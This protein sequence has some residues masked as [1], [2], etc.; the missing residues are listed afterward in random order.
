MWPKHHSDHT[1]DRKQHPEDDSQQLHT[2]QLLLALLHDLLLP[3]QAWRCAVRP[4]RV[5]LLNPQA[6]SG[7][8]DEAGVP[9]VALQGEHHSLGDRGQAGCHG[10]WQV[11]GHGGQ[12]GQNAG[13][14]G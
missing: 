1:G 7:Q 13:V 3:H 10:L 2:E 14:A 6:D 5:H 11:E 9:V 12:S 8:D 4:L